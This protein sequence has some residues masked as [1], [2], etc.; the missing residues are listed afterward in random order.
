MTDQPRAVLGMWERIV[1]RCGAQSRYSA[2]AATKAKTDFV[3]RREA[4][5]SYRIHASFAASF[6]E[7]GSV[8]MGGA[9][10]WLPVAL[11]ISDRHVWRLLAMIERTERVRSLAAI[12]HGGHPADNGA[13][14]CEKKS[15]R[16]CW[17]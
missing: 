9:K 14:A 11:R 4:R 1:G 10:L 2:I 8:Q 17:Q 15:H 16:V 3:L 6:G 13:I 5:I 7:A 12:V